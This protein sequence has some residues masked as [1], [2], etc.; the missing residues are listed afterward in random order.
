[1]DRAVG[2]WGGAMLSTRQRRRLCAGGGALLSLAG[3]RAQAQRVDKISAVD[4]TRA[5]Q[6]TTLN[7]ATGAAFRLSDD[8]NAQYILN[9]RTG[10]SKIE[11]HCAWDDLLLVQSGVGIVRTSRK[12]KGL[13]KY[14]T[15]EWRAESLVQASEETIAPGDVMRIP[16]GTGHVITSLGDAPLIYLVVKLRTVDERACGSLPRRGQ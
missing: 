16:A 11:M 7:D 6:Q 10:P 2:D 9:R 14:S 1:M 8:G 5:A 4:I 3:G 12:F 15:W 13:A